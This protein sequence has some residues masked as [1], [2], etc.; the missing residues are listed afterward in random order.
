MWCCSSTLCS[1]ATLP[2]IWG[3]WA[4]KGH[5]EGKTLLALSHLDSQY[6]HTEEPCSSH[7]F[8]QSQ[9]RGQQ[10]EAWGSSV[11]L[12]HVFLLTVSTQQPAFVLRYP[13]QL[14]DA[15]AATLN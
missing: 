10:G 4:V 11:V 14:W 8:V 15:A 7:L 6:R 9:G 2:G 5:G 3:L 13:W 1:P 12:M